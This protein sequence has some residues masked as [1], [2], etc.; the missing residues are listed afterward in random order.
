MYTDLPAATDRTWPLLWCH[1]DRLTAP[2]G[3]NTDEAAAWHT[4]E[5]ATKAV[6]RGKEG[7][8][9]TGGGPAPLSLS[10]LDSLLADTLGSLNIVQ[11]G[12]LERMEPIITSEPSAAPQL[13][14]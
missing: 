2:T 5:E 1:S 9:Q 6:W 7:K 12:C 14:Q 4:L 10:E 13:K 3:T 11:V 8:G